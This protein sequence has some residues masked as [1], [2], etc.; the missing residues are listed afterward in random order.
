MQLNAIKVNLSLWCR[1]G[2]GNKRNRPGAEGDSVHSCIE[3][4]SIMNVNNRY[5]L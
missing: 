1:D 4:Y 5:I 2:L 3:M